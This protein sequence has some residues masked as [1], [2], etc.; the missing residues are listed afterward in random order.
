MNSVTSQQERKDRI[1]RQR[2]MD[3]TGWHPDPHAYRPER[4]AGQPQW[5]VHRLHDFE[6]QRHDNRVADQLWAVRFFPGGE[7]DAGDYHAQAGEDSD[8]PHFHDNHSTTFS[9]FDRRSHRRS[10]DGP[11][12]FNRPIRGIGQQQAQPR[13]HRGRRSRRTQC[14][15]ACAGEHRGPVRHR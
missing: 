6:D 5:P 9:N 2:P 15:G 11:A 3:G 13:L 8:N 7:A 4:K 10:V 1:Q 14:P 12:V